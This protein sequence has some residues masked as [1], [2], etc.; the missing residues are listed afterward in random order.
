MDVVRG[1]VFE[2]KNRLMD[3]TFAGVLRSV[4]HKSAV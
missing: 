4:D 3:V 2:Y 1:G